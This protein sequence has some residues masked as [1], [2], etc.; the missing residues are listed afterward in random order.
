MSI[1]NRDEVGGKLEQA[2]GTVKETVGDLTDIERMEREGEAD[3]AGGETRE[4]WGKVK[5]GVGDAIDAVGDAIS[6]TG[7][8]INK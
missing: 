8:N 7:K 4:T 3:R 1:P 5:H 2:K 6:D